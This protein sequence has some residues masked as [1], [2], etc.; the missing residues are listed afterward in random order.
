MKPL[1]LRASLMAWF[2]ALAGFLLLAF[3]AVLSVRIGA[4]LLDGM[5]AQLRATATGLAALAEWDE[6][7][8][9]VEF[10]WIGPPLPGRQQSMEVWTWPQGRLLYQSGPALDC[11][12]PPASWT[13]GWSLQRESK[14]EFQFLE[15]GEAE[16]RLCTLVAEIPEV[17]PTEEDPREP[18]FQVLVRVAGSTA[19]IAAKRAELRWLLVLL[20]G[21][22]AGIV[23]VFGFFLSRRFVEPLQALGAAASKIQAGQASHWPRRGTGDEVDHLADLLENAFTRL[24]NALS[25]Q[26]RFTSDAAH[27]LRNPIAAIQSS[28]EVAVRKERSPE[29]YRTFLD[30]ILGTSQRMGRVVEALLLLA[31]LDA[32]KVERSFT[33]VPLLVLARETAGAQPQAAGRIQMEGDETLSVLGDEALL[34]VLIG[35]LISNALRYSEAPKM[36]E[37]SVRHENCPC[38]EVRDQGP[39]IPANAKEHIFDRF[40]RVDSDSKSTN[41]AGLGLALVAEIARLHG[42]I[43][44]VESS[45][46]GSCFS[47]RF[48]W[49][50]QIDP[51][52]KSD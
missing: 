4:A 18:S 49:I 28:A 12:K 23:V 11:D 36:V 43:I 33:P 45:P 31:R 41:G 13:A 6:E 22:S 25:K 42:A 5:D 20:G 26:R 32:G 3:S 44:E 47:V 27:E 50:P 39:G 17:P 30:D 51:E 34:R 40:Y 37:I 9:E 1:S 2:V 14:C 29:E 10:E 46:A 24:E 48:P 21:I 7:L 16:R 8:G 19:P 38:I 52:S 15:Q 35:N